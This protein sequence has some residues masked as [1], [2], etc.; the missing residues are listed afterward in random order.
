MKR[1]ENKLKNI[2]MNIKSFASNALMTINDIAKSNSRGQAYYIVT[3]GSSAANAYLKSQI[4]D[5]MQ[6][7]TDSPLYDE[8]LLLPEK[9]WRKLLTGTELRYIK[10]VLFPA[11]VKKSIDKYAI[12][13]Q[14][15]N[16]KIDLVH[17]LLRSMYREQKKFID[18]L[19]VIDE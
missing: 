10:T 9:Q 1:L 11:L 2:L 8:R 14:S 17:S 12:G 4:I 15:T 13:I 16:E 3:T 6:Q 5:N 19:N 18:F 7:K